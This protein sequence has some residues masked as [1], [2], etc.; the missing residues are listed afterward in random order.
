[1]CR[2]GCGPSPFYSYL[3]GPGAWMR[4]AGAAERAA[5]AA[6]LGGGRLAA[7]FR[8]LVRDRNNPTVCDNNLFCENND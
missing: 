2:P 8:L 7:S 1:M 4:P 3:R 6:T 5:R